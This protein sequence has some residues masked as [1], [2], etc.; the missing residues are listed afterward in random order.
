MRVG[1]RGGVAEALSERRPRG[2]GRDWREGMFHDAGEGNGAR[3]TRARNQVGVVVPLAAKG[4]P[5]PVLSPGRITGCLR[6]RSQQLPFGD[7]SGKTRQ[8]EGVI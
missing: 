4:R 2:G 1:L 6:G 7:G 5:T 8:G 3:R